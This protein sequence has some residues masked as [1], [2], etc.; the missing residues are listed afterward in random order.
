MAADHRVEKHFVR[1]QSFF[2]VWEDCN[3]FI[4]SSTRLEGAYS[5]W[6]TLLVCVP[7]GIRVSLG[8]GEIHR[9]LLPTCGEAEKFAKTG[10]QYGN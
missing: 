6:S 10:R 5:R 8:T 2:V 1:N 9:V 3:G 7:Q 4:L